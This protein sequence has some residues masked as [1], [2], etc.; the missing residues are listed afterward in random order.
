MEKITNIKAQVRA[1]WNLEKKMGKPP[2]KRKGP[3]GDRKSRPGR[4]SGRHMGHHQRVIT[5]G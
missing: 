1:A 5:G 2:K 4:R 3:S